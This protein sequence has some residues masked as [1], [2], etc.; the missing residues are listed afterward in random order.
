MLWQMGGSQ[1]QRD[2]FFLLLADSARR[3]ARQDLLGIIL[4]DIAAAGFTDPAGRIGYRQAA[5]GVH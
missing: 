5:A 2:L 1:A 4:D 3:L